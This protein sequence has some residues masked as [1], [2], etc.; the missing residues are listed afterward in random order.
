LEVATD[1]K[2]I[3]DPFREILRYDFVIKGS[4]IVPLFYASSRHRSRAQIVGGAIRN[5]NGLVVFSPPPLNWEEPRLLDYL[6]AISELAGALKRPIGD[7]PAWSDAFTSI[8]EQDATTRIRELQKEIET[9]TTESNNN[10]QVVSAERRLKLLYAGTGDDLVTVTAFAL[11]ELGFRV[12]EGP[13]RRAD[14]LAWDG[15][16]LAAAEVKGLDGTV[17]ENNFRQAERWIAEVNAALTMAPAERKQDPELEQYAERLTELGLELSSPVTD[18]ECRGL[19]IIATHRQMPL[20][21]RPS[22]SFPD[23][24]ARLLARSTVCAL[25]G[26]DLYCF[27][28][29]A[30][31]NEI[32]RGEIAKMLLAEGGVVA[33]QDWRDVVTRI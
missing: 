20:D 14:L 8:R 18:V 27:L 16:R 11:R 24:V 22:E 29:Q 31:N 15:K 2:S 13:K 21:Q 7:A 30:R 3:F 33:A 17:R 9:L 19:M 28:Q 25:T 6:G 4:N 12:T 32:R 23:P 26:L 5:G 1:F 10:A